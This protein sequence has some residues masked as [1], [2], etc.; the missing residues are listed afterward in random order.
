MIHHPLIDRLAA[1]PLDKWLTVAE[2]KRD[3]KQTACFCPFCKGE[4]KPHFIVYDEQLGGMYGKPVK[5]WACTKT[6]RTGYGALELLSAIEGLPMTGYGLYMLA[7]KMQERVPDQVPPLEPFDYRTEAEQPVE[8]LQFLPRADFMAQ[9]LTALG[10][11]VRMDVKGVV[12]YGFGTTNDTQPWQFKPSM[13]TERFLIRPLA[14]CVLP[15]MPRKEKMVSER[16]FGT[17]WNPLFICFTDETE[18]QGCIFRPAMSLAPIAFSLNDEHTA[19][20]VSRWL[21]G[22]RVFTKALEY[23]SEETTGVARAI[24]DLCPTEHYAKRR[25]IWEEAE[26]GKQTLVMEDIPEKR[27]LADNIIFCASPQDAVATYFHLNAI[28]HTYPNNPQLNA[29][30]FHVAFSFGGTPFSSVHHRKMGRFAQRTYTLFPIDDKSTKE[31]RVIGR[32]FRDVWRASLPATFRSVVFQRYSRMFGRKVCSPRDFFLAYRM[33]EEESFQYDHDLNRL[34]LTTIGAALTTSPFERKEK[35]DKNGNVREQ[36]FVIDPA[37]LWEF[38]ASEGYMR[39]V[40]PDDPDKIGRF[41]HLDGPFV[42]ELDTRSMLAKTAE[43]LNDYARQVARPGSDDYRLMKQAVARA[44][45][46]SDKTVVGI[47]PTTINYMGGYGPKLDHFFYENGAL[48]ITNDTIS[49]VPYSQLDFNVDRGEVLHWR[50]SMPYM[51]D[52]KTPF[53][54]DENKEYRDRLNAIEAHRKEVDAN[55]RPR[56]TLQQIAAERSDLMQWARL[57]RWKVTWGEDGDVKKL[58]PALRVL[59][60][61][62]NEHWEREEELMR[63]GRAFSPDEQAELNGHF[64][65]LLFCLGRMLWR[66]RDNRSNCIPYLMENTVEN[67]KKA[68]GGSGKSSFLKVFAAC[69]GYVLNVDSKNIVQ[70]RDFTLSLAEYRPHHHRVVHWEDWTNRLSLEQ[71]YNYAT[72]GFSYRRMF[73]NAVTVKLN[74]A[75]CHVITSNYPPS[76]NDDSTMRRICIGGFS[77][78]FCGENTL[79]NKS[80]RYITDIMPDFSASGPD[81]LTPT[82]RNQI[83]YICALAVQ[84][85]MRFDEKVDAPQEDLKYRA[86]VRTLGDSFV[87]WATHFFAQS[88]VYTIPVD[89]DSAMQEFVSEYSDASD[90]KMDKFS[91]KT[92]YQK[93]VD[94]CRTIAVECN[95]PQIYRKGSKAE[96]RRYFALQAW[97]TQEYFK[98]K[99][100]DDDP[101]VHPK[102]IRELRRSEYV[103]FFYRAEDK[104]PANNDE[105]MAAYADFVDKGVDPAPI[106][107]EKGN[108]VYITDEE[109][110]RWREYKDRRQG[111]YTGGSSQTAATQTTNNINMDDMPF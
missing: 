65:N 33:T 96:Q 77:H 84:F 41:V 35:R 7:R 17:P 106:L 109:Q 2:E 37:T 12:Q 60:G 50:F 63:E 40:K 59:R 93:V 55:G 87:R 79:Q 8:Q 47:P 48:R 58:W 38:M 62:A 27:V 88:W 32:R 5:R 24:K 72:S 76:N 97:C 110:R 25:E 98:G 81:T 11:S 21:G 57:H 89:L 49:F 46:I 31:A 61:F 108:R 91:R 69:A 22:D 80:A 68:S 52:N 42:D 90:N 95:P 16:I 85:V 44:R 64:A 66:Y 36:Y 73:E 56:Y 92:F 104:R 83:A 70:G 71:L 28:R 99:D 45:E 100:W 102:T 3:A 107:D 4:T 13:I 34:F 23:R 94:Y 78:R 67:E 51:K 74:E 6:R 101:T 105:L 53:T 15:A 103:V 54:I 111:H 86:M 43:C 14:E 10:C 75:P 30:Y 1:L 39:D 82:T 18:K 20:K 29:R 26:N 9:E 19:T